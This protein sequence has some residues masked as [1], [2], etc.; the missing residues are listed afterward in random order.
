MTS[1]SRKEINVE[2]FIDGKE[3]F[4]LSRQ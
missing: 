4:V 3:A 1:Q 2:K